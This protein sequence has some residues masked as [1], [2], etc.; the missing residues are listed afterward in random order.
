[1]KKICPLLLALAL[2]LS[3]TACGGSQADPLAEP[4]MPPSVAAIGDAVAAAH[5]EAEQTARTLESITPKNPS[6]IL[7]KESG[8]DPEFFP[9]SYALEADSPT[10]AYGKVLW[11]V[12]QYGLLPGE[13]SRPTYTYSERAPGNSFAV[14]DIDNDGREELL[15]Y[16]PRDIM[17]AI[18]TYVWEYRDGVLYEELVTFPDGLIFYDNGVVHE[19]WSHNQGSRT[20]EIFWPYALNIYDPEADIYKDAGSVNA[21]DVNDHYAGDFPTDIDQ[22][23]DG[24][25]Y[26]LHRAGEK[27]YHYD[28]YGNYIEKPPVDGPVYEEWRD[29]ILRDG[30]PVEVPWL[31]LTQENISTLG[32]P[33]PEMPD[34]MSYIPG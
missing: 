1:M 34:W 10:E 29:S 18:K 2:V 21:W 3:L 31:S 11:Y 14:Y 5:N 32:Y 7:P 27:W 28:K 17:A 13:D 26:Y 6:K 15:F 4:E 24:I 9:S 19:D 16:W 22:D 12:F 20:S 30:Q 25:V 33:E 23:R 8:E